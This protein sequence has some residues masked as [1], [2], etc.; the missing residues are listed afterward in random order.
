MWCFTPKS[1]T[2]TDDHNGSPVYVGVTHASKRSKLGV[3]ALV[4]ELREIDIDGAPILFHA[5][6]GRREH[7]CFRTA[8]DLVYTVLGKGGLMEQFEAVDGLGRGI[9]MHAA[10]SN[11]LQTFKEI[12]NTYVKNAALMIPSSKVDTIAD[13]RTE[14]S[15]YVRDTTRR[16]GCC[17][18][19]HGL[20]F[21]AAR[22]NVLRK[23]LEYTDHV[24]MNCLHHAAE[25][26]CC[27]VLKEVIEKCQGVETAYGR[28]AG[29]TCQRGCLKDYADKTWSGDGGDNVPFFMK[30]NA[31]EKSASE[32]TPIMYVLR[33][34]GCGQECT[35]GQNQVLRDKF[36]TLYEAMPCRPMASSREP[37]RMGWMAPS[38]VLPPPPKG[39][40][41]TTDGVPTS[42]H[43][44]TE[45]LHAARGG[46]S[47]LELALNESLPASTE[48]DGSIRTVN[49]DDALH[50]KVSTNGARWT[51]ND[52]TKTWGRA[53]L[54]AA[55]AKRGDEDALYQVLLAIEVSLSTAFHRNCRNQ[56]SNWGYRS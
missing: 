30:M 26:G 31:A 34:M 20:A 37:H 16:Q 9:L 18:D 1:A 39:P 21:S 48:D 27:D 23:V 11:H 42:A 40:N 24:G 28:L 56:L 29:R 25:A 17:N 14:L 32:R 38:N 35:D 13:A 19:C 50:V 43:A 7:S 2:R 5:A 22:A 45:L 33:N 49:L 15:N 47:S 54:L 44:F 46:L 8:C 55:A 41:G 3:C 36:Y 53:L 4:K 52:E 10:R 6:S 51:S 12:C